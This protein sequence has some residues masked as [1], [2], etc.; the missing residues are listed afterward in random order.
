MKR[1]PFSILPAPLLESLS[2]NFENFG[3]FT[4]A[5]FP[6]MHDSLLQAE[7]D[8]T[9]RNY[10][11]LAFTAAFFNSFAIVLL[12]VVIAV[13]T[14]NVSMLAFGLALMIIVFFATFITI[15][16]Y[17][18]V[19]AG[20]RS[21]ELDATLIP[22]VRQLL[23]EIKSGV[24]LFNSMASVS[25][26]YGEVSKEFRK[27]VQKINSGVPELDAIAESTTSNPNPQ[28]RRVLWQISNALKVGSDV[29]I[30]LELQVA[31]LTRERIDQIRKYGQE[32]SPFTMIYMMAAVIVPSLGL[33]MLIVV[34]G[35]LNV[36][37][38]KLLL[39]AVL[40]GLTGFQLFFMNFVGSRR[41]VI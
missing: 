18:Q 4:S 41:P 33:T 32:L 31:E 26:D 29:A 6:F 7:S 13:V 15:L 30:V 16:Y 1:I 22:A 34:I 5:F 11:A 19:I 21:R 36:V 14:H 10:A 20:K 9:A 8:Y 23:I 39:I 37:V 3:Y 25:T 40:G 24:P 12:F 27:I 2:H 35:L 17:P 38:P 28:F